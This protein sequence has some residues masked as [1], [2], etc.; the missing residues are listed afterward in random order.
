MG[1]T[2]PKETITVRFSQRLRPLKL[3]KEEHALLGHELAMVYQTLYLPEPS[4]LISSQMK[5]LTGEA[6]FAES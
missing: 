3:S 1:L 2:D 6:L 4:M 5:Q